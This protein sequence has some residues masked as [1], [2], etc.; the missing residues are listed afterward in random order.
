MVRMSAII[1]VLAPCVG[2]RIARRARE[3]IYEL[4]P[5]RISE[6]GNRRYRA[7]GRVTHRLDPSVSDPAGALGCWI[8]PRRRQRHRRA[9][10]GSMAFGADRPAIPCR[11]PAGCG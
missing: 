7:L 10:D 1:E 3:E 8:C 11:K 4:S 2:A 6:A 9:F 5:Q